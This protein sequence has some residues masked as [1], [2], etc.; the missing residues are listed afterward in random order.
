MKKDLVA[1][2]TQGDMVR[3][4]SGREEIDFPGDEWFYAISFIVV[5]D[6]KRER[7]TLNNYAT[8]GYDKAESA[9]RAQQKAD[10]VNAKG[11][12]LSEWTREPSFEERMNDEYLREQSERW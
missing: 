2:P 8:A 3:I 6:Y 12:D 11:I 9:A 7:Y 4:P 1:Y 5:L 10:E